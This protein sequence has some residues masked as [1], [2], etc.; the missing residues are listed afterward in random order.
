MLRKKNLIK[1]QVDLSP[2][3]KMIGGLWT[4]N[5]KEPPSSFV[6]NYALISN[7]I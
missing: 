7:F 1:Y 3:I 4:Q 5:K 6:Y 2:E